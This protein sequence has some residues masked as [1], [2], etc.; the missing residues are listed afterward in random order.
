VIGV[1]EAIPMTHHYTRQRGKATEVPYVPLGLDEV[2]MTG[3]YYR[4]I[5]N[6]KLYIK[7]SGWERILCS[8][9]LTDNIHL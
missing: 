2:I 7:G 5:R 4:K 6:P 1:I 9:G 3:T 8:T